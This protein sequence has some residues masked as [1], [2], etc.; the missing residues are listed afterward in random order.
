MFDSLWWLLTI[1]VGFVLFVVYHFFIKIYIVAAQFK[2]M[3][4]SLQILVTPIMGLLGIQRENFRKYGDSLRYVKDMVKENPDTKAYFTNIGYLPMLILCDAQLVKEYL[5]GSKKFRKFNLYKHNDI[6]YKQGLFLADEELWTRQKAIVKHSFNHEN[7]KRMIPSMEMSIRRYTADLLTKIQSN[8]NTS[9]I[10]DKKSVDFKVLHDTETLI[11]EILVSIIF[12]EEAIDKKVNGCPLAI[13]L[14][15]ATVNM[16]DRSRSGPNLFWSLFFG[17]KVAT[18]NLSKKDK[19]LY[20]LY[21]EI[22]KIIN[23]ILDSRLAIG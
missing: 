2:K 15:V 4:P 3:D 5:L 16:F 12:T 17:E 21:M 1:P 19:D 9:L 23:E 10:L 18:I 7:M 13:A 22:R 8:G 14:A 11:G 6:T 20:D